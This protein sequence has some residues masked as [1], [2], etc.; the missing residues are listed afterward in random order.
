MKR[1]QW[2][3]M[4]QFMTGHNHLARHNYVVDPTENPTCTL[5]DFGYPQ[6][7]AHIVGECPDPH[8]TQIRIDLFGERYMEPP[9]DH[10]APGKV[11]AFLLQSGLPALD[12]WPKQL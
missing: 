6:D 2:G 1:T 10:L 11:L 5:C 12:W 4:V 3:K 7:T 8:L 9:F